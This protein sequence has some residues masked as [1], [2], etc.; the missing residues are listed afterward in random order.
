[1]LALVPDAGAAQLRSSTL[2]LSLR[3]GAI[4]ELVN[5]LSGEGFLSRPERPALPAGLHRLGEPMLEVRNAQEAATRGILTQSV[6]WPNAG[7][8]DLRAEIEPAT[9]D[10]IITQ[11]GESLQKKLAG[12]SW[13]VA[14][15]PDRFDVLVPGWS[16]QRFSADLPVG[17]REFEYPITWEASFV[18]IQGRRGGWLIRAEDDPPR[19]KNLI[20]EHAQRHFRLRFESRNLAPFQDKDRIES[21][22]WRI[23]AYRGSWQTGAAMYR[24][25]AESHRP[26]KPL[27]Q[28]QPAWV[29]QIRL[30]VTIRPE[31]SLLPLLA[32]HCEPPR[33]LLYV[34]GWRRDGYDRN[35]PDYTAVPQFDAFVTEAHRLGFRVMPHVNYFGCDPLNPVYEQ[36]R[37]AQIR[38]PISGEPL[39]W[40]WPARPPIKFAYINPASRAWRELFLERM[41]ELVRRHNVDALHLD[42]TLCIYNDANGPVDGLTAIEGTLALHRQLRTALPHIALSGEGLNEITGQYQAFAQ[43]HLWSMDHMNRTWDERAP[44]MSHPVSSAVLSPYTH[45]Y[46]YLG[47]PNPARAGFF[48]VWQRAYEPLGVLPTYNHPDAAQL[49]DPPRPVADLLALGRFFQ[50]HLPEPDFDAPWRKNELFVYRLADGRRAAYRRENGTLLVLQDASP[51]RVSRPGRDEVLFRRIEGVS[52]AELEGSIPGWPAYDRKRFFG[53]DPGQSYPWSARP[54]DLHQPRLAAL[55]D[56]VVLRQAGMHADFARFRFDEPKTARSISLW[57]FAGPVRAGVEF[58]NGTKRSGDALDFTDE[59]SGARVHPEREGLFLHPPWRGHAAAHMRPVSFIEFDVSLPKTRRLRFEAQVQLRDA[60]GDKSDGVSVRVLARCGPRE[61]RAEVHHAGAGVTPLGLDLTTFA[62]R[63]VMLRLEVDAGPANDSSF[64]WARINRPQIRAEADAPPTPRRVVFTG[65]K[66]LR[67]AWSFAEPVPVMQ[68][69][70]G[71]LSLNIS[72][73]GVLI[74]AFAEPTAVPAPCDLLGVSFSRHLVACNGIESP[75]A[76]MPDHVLV[77]ASCGGQKRRSLNARPPPEGQALTDWLLRLPDAPVKLLTAAGLRDG[78][79]S[80][81]VRFSVLVNAQPQLA[82]SLRAG[83]GWRPVELDLTAWRGRPVLL[84]L[85]T[86]VENRPLDDDAVWDEPRL[87]LLEPPSGRAAANTAEQA[88]IR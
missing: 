13:A 51:A 63:K 14:G 88:T 43:R 6:A 29:N 27:A 69:P 39:W 46:G 48:A 22:R 73:P 66:P 67:A 84:S 87:E 17:R 75:L 41:T 2:S 35:Y 83:D 53:L 74:L 77:Q 12:I 86:E 44:A 21:S 18:L 47:M 26:L 50:R 15:I 30:V 57:D 33:T 37:H 32:R 19:F 34:P 36:L 42:Q 64:D 11:T 8:F 54:R 20:V 31:P 10:V 72:P 81:G 61:L 70:D 7:H 55:P 28:Q 38:D 56:G 49:A 1:M 5:R 60:A 23:T 71:A 25:W 59:I 9:G 58:A 16:G 52:V 45:L 3:D 40:E 78:A 4:I 24:R 85:A 82:C 79:S 65:L 80:Q 62:G 68:Q 76:N